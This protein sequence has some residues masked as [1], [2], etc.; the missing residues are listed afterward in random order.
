MSEQV[1][2]QV[3]MKKE[4]RQAFKVACTKD[5]RTVAGVIRKLIELYTKGEIKL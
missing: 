2:L 5:G 4:D 3:R 1:V